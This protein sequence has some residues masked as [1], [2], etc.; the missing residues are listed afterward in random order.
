[1]KTSLFNYSNVVTNPKYNLFILLFS[2]SEYTVWF[3]TLFFLVAK[4]W[5]KH[6]QRHYP[7]GTQIF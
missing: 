1:M 6:V 5:H 7:D 3:L 2:G 4:G